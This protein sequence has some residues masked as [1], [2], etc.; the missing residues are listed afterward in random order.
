MWRAIGGF[1][2]AVLLTVVTA[3]ALAAPVNGQL[4]AVVDE[5]LVTLNPDGSGLRTLWTAPRGEAISGLAW[6]PDGNRLA[7]SATRRIAVYDLLTG[8]VAA[9]TNPP[10]D[11]LDANPGWSADGT[12]IGFRRVAATAA[13]PWPWTPPAATRRSS[14]S[15]IDDA[16]TALAWLPNLS[17]ATLVVGNQLVLA[18][19]ANSVAG[20]R[21]AGLGARRLPD[22]V[23]QRQ[24]DPRGRARRSDSVAAWPPP[25]PGRR[26][27]R[28]TPVRS[29]IRRAPSCASSRPRAASPASC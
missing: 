15:S 22:R 27:G 14:R 24:R 26:G 18:G 16:T 11:A 21:R 7:F 17:G 20:R 5:Q 28:P 4:A 1:A 10:T 8:K 3:P 13:A 6:S 2:C 29:S 9:I 23:R 25:R 19:L 12:R